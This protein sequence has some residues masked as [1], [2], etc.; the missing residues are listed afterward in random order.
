MITLAEAF[1]GLYAAWRLFLRDARGLTLLDP[2]PAGAFRSF[3]CA[4][5]VL[6][7][8]A[9]IV[10]LVHPLGMVEIDWF[11]FTLVESVTYVVSWCAWPLLMFYVTQALDRSDRFYLYVAA[12][13]WSAGPQVAIWLLVLI[14]VFSG[15]VS[16][17]VAT[18]INI[19]ALVVI[20]MYHL[21]I[22]RQTLKLGLFVSIGLVAGEAMLT[23]FIELIRV[24]M[25]H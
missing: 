2:T 10:I 15:I 16:R 8:Y 17:E 14:V 9:L 4:L 6:P 13:N 18:I 5:I 3:W 7:V 1:T 25:M 23:Q 11:R 19:A 24:S 22:V 21:F 12:F 20:L